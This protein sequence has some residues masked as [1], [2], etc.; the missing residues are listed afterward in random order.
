[1]REKFENYL[2]SQGYKVKTP[3]GN[4]STAYDYVKRIENICDWEKCNWEDIAKSID[5][6]VREYDI[7]GSKEELGNKSHRAVINALKR[8]REFVKQ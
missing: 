8:Y 5:L 4:P 6:L 3:S 7:G 1:M 2:V